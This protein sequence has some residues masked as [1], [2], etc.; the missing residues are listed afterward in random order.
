MGLFI[1]CISRGRKLRDIVL[2]S[3][4]LPALYNLV[5]FCT[6]GGIGLRQDR[7]A[8]ELEIL[9]NSLFNNSKYF[10]V[11]GSETCY[12]VPQTDLSFGNETFENSLLGITPVCKFDP[13]MPGMASLNVLRS[14]QF[15]DSYKHGLG[16]ILI[17]FHLLAC[18]VYFIAVSNTSSFMIDQIASNARKNHHWARRLFWACSAAALATALLSQ[19]EEDA[20][21]ALKAAAVVFSPPMIMLTCYILQSIVLLCRAAERTAAG[22][23]YPLPDQPEFKMPICGGVFNYMEYMFS[24]GKVNPI[25]VK[26][27]MDR[28]LQFHQVE[29]VRSLVLPFATLKLVLMSAYPANQKLNTV[30]VACYGFCYACWVGL[31]LASFSVPALGELSMIFFLVSG[32]ILGM[33]RSGFR[34]RYHLRSNTIGDLVSSVFFWPQVLT[35]MKLQC[36]AP[37]EKVNGVENDDES[38][39]KV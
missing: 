21:N 6:W 20:M 10:L 25:R 35:Q 3:C 17:A 22:D 27:G 38:S 1:A 14:F 8:Q 23:D 18:A 5:N 34:E 30:V 11:D 9:G 12:A 7:Q 33:I 19:G 29:F 16:S 39:Q 36:V 13:Q 28:P 15:P 31:L 32:V 24:L 2:Y 4:F 26:L 37:M